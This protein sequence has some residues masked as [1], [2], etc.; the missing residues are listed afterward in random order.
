MFYIRPLIRF[1][2]IGLALLGFSI[3]PASAVVLTFDDLPGGSNQNAYG[4][5]MPYNQFKFSETLDWLDLEGSRW[6][7]GAHSGDFGILNNLGGV[8]KITVAGNADF[9]FDGLWAKAWLTPRESGGAD[10]VFGL[11]SGYNDGELVWS[12]PTGL[13]GSYKF[14]GAQQGLIDELHLGLGH[15]FLVDDISLN[16]SSYPPVLSSIRPVSPI[17]VPAA[18]WLFGTALIGLA[19]FSKRRKTTWSLLKN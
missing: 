10:T 13:N 17:P 8:G 4:D 11:L 2:L 5:M 16:E 19:G 14:F 12:T 3:T 18:F 9:T 7:Y 15:F 1:T 6:N